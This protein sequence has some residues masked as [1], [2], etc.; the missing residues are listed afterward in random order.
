MP[1]CARACDSLTQNSM[2]V[3]RECTDQCCVC[4]FEGSHTPHLVQDALLV[5]LVVTDK[6]PSSSRLIVLRN[7][8]SL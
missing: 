4:P 1:V 3:V 8:S 6:L 7:P 5:M 2:E